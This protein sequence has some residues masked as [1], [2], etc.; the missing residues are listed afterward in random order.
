MLIEGHFENSHP[1][2]QKLER[3]NQE[4][5]PPDSS[6]VR[7]PSDGA[8]DSFTVVPDKSHCPGRQIRYFLAA[9]WI[10]ARVLRF[11]LSAEDALFSAP[12]TYTQNH[13]DIF[14]WT[15]RSPSR[16]N[17]SEVRNAPSLKSETMSLSS[18]LSILGT[19]TKSAERTHWQPE[20]NLQLT[21]CSIRF[22]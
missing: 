18:P 10:L 4:W 7:Y 3:V 11:C 21:L 1:E 14:R 13:I 2:E 8:I 5:P 9:L 19:A 20:M 17:F 16:T 15:I 12:A 22:V 6:F